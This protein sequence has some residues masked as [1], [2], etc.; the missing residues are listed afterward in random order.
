[1]KEQAIEKINNNR[2][3]SVDNRFDDY[4]LHS[5]QCQIR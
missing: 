1:M 5:G 4:K 3:D 2:F